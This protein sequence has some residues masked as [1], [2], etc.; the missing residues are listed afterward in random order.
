MHQAPTEV[1][2]CADYSLI[3]D[4]RNNIRTHLGHES[5]VR[6]RRLKARR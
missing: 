1:F 6:L 4:K 3:R 5:H 2:I